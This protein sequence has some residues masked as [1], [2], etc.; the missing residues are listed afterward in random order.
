MSKALI[1][2]LATAL[3]ILTG[4]HSTIS[5]G[6][7]L[8]PG[9]TAIYAGGNMITP[10]KSKNAKKPM[11]RTVKRRAYCGQLGCSWCCLTSSGHANCRRIARCGSMPK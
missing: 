1:A 5:A 4:S 3:L 8:M 10:V 2:I 7:K 6:S 11:N 9:P